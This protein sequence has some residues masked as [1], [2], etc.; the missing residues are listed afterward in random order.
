MMM[1]VVFG[2]NLSLIQTPTLKPDVQPLWAFMVGF[3]IL[4]IVACAVVATETIIF[5]PVQ[6]ILMHGLIGITTLILPTLHVVGRL[7]LLNSIGILFSSQYIAIEPSE[8]LLT[9]VTFSLGT[10]IIMLSRMIGQLKQNRSND[11]MD[12]YLRNGVNAYVIKDPDYQN[13]FVSEQFTI[14]TGYDAETFSS[15]NDFYVDFEDKKRLLRRPPVGDEVLGSRID[16]G[17]CKIRCKNGS[18]KTF[19]VIPGYLQ[20]QMVNSFYS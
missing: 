15:V 16:L 2:A 4:V 11:R 8:I 13:V 9:I 19:I 14:M 20:G 7:L 6:M 3:T 5:T 12:A 10:L 17:I 1:P 18:E